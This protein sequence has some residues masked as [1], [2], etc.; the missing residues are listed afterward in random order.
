MSRWYRRHTPSK[1]PSLTAAPSLPPND[2]PECTAVDQGQGVV[3][4]RGN[5]SS[6]TRAG[7]GPQR[8]NARAIHA[9]ERHYDSR[10]VCIVN[11]FGGDFFARLVRSSWCGRERR[12]AAALTALVFNRRP[13]D[14]AARGRR[15]YKRRAYY[16]DLY[17]L[18]FPPQRGVSAASYA[19]GYDG[20]LVGVYT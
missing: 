9:C 20:D 6:C 16:A 5:R 18:F 2:A 14:T 1:Q 10:Y 11:L 4:S 15:A 8:V 12:A 17:F 13:S 3:S 19:R 7:T